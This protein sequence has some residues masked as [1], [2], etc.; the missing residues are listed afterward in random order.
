MLAATLRPQI[1]SASRTAAI[2]APARRISTETVIPVTGRGV[3]V[4][5]EAELP[6]GT[7]A[8]PLEVDEEEGETEPGRDN[9]DGAGELLMVGAGCDATRRRQFWHRPSLAMYAARGMC[10]LQARQKTGLVLSSLVNQ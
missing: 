6:P 10:C 9:P 4:F 5:S 3:R 1:C 7:I 2:T 8:E